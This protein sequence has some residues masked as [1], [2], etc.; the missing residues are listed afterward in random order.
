M[1]NTKPFN[2]NTFFTSSEVE[3]VLSGTT[4]KSDRERSIIK[5]YMYLKVK[6]SWGNISNGDVCDLLHNWKAHL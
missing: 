5:A 3:K 2:P 1:E 6:H 4:Y